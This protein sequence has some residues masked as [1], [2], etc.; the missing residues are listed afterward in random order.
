MKEKEVDYGKR[1]LELFKKQ[2]LDMCSS[3]TARCC[4]GKASELFCL[5]FPKSGMMQNGIV[6]KQGIL[7][8]HTKEKDCLSLP[9]PN[10]SDALVILSQ[11]KSIKKVF[12]KKQQ[13]TVIYHCQLNGLTPDQTT[14]LYECIMGFPPNW[15]KIE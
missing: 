12:T 9:T 3:K 5:I 7:T 15:T 8:C 4:L 1:C 10:A 11:K 6:Y 2:D 14:T 13:E